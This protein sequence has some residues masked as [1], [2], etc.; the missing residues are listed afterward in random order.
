MK[1]LL[2]Y[3]FGSDARSLQDAWDERDWAVICMALGANV[4]LVVGCFGIWL[5]FFTA[6]AHIIHG[7]GWAPW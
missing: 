3:Y 5:A 4:V 1:R 6:S 7:L 2:D